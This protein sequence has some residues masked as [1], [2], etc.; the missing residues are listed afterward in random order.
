MNLKL[1]IF[2]DVDGGH[3][4]QVGL[5][6][7]GQE[8]LK[9]IAPLGKNLLYTIYKGVNLELK[10]LDC[11]VNDYGKQAQAAAKEALN[12]SNQQDKDAQGALPALT[13]DPVLPA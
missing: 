10:H 8:A 2:K 7:I 11:V 12:G 6:V 9:V 5:D 13:Q 3:M 4:L 1:D